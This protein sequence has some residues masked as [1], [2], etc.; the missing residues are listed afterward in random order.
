MSKLLNDSIENKIELIISLETDVREDQRQ[1]S[2]LE[3]KPVRIN[4]KFTT[5]IAITKTKL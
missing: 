5:L 3:R 4:G 1:A 2:Q